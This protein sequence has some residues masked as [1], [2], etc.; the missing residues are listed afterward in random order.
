MLKGGMDNLMKQAQKMQESSPKVSKMNE[1]WFKMDTKSTK[2]L[3]NHQ[4]IYINS[5]NRPKSSKM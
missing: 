5:P 3:Q 2:T 1:M 4:K